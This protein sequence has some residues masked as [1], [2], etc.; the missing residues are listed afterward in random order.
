MAMLN[1][2]LKETGWGKSM[3]NLSNNLGGLK[4]RVELLVSRIDAILTPNQPCTPKPPAQP[5]PP[6]AK[7]LHEID[8]IAVRIDEL[9]NLV[10]DTIIR[11][12]I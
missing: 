7:A 10:D 5:M 4:D 11:L 8:I 6:I 9:K 12:E 1:E 3:G 2:P